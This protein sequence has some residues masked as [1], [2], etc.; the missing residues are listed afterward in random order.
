MHI[1]PNFKNLIHYQLGGA[2]GKSTY[3]LV[4]NIFPYF[5]DR[6]KK[7]LRSHVLKGQVRA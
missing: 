3:V 4:S 5:F 7:C 2:A 6:T 1:I